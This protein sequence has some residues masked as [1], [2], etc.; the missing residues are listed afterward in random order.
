MTIAVLVLVAAATAVAVWRMRTATSAARASAALSRSQLEALLRVLPDTVTFLDAEGRT[1]LASGRSP[2]A[3]DTASPLGART[4]RHQDGTPLPAGQHPIERAMRGESFAGWSLSCR[5]AA[6]GH[7]C[8]LT[9]GGAPVLDARGRQVESV[10]VARDVSAWVRVE[11]MLRHSQK[12][13]AVGTMAAGI[14][15]DFN[16]ILTVIIGNGS[17]ARRNAADASVKPELEA[18]LHAARRGAAMTARLLAFTRRRRADVR[19]VHPGTILRALEP[20]MRRLQTPAL[21]LEVTDWTD[22]DDVVIADAAS[23]EQVIIGLFTLAQ[24]SIG[25]GGVLSIMCESAWADADAV[26]AGQRRVTI[27][28]GDLHEWFEAEQACVDAAWQSIEGA[29]P[30]GLALVRELMARYGGAVRIERTEVAGTVV[31]VSW[32]IANPSEGAA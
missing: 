26:P 1:V 11:A 6:T 27:S 22:G 9:Y 23:I 18:I 17:L 25:E 21:T 30:L 10:I 29:S 7:E 13:Q 28:V 14:T 8:L 31:T 5:D 2:Q 24:Q 32:P 3:A 20:L 19:A 16:N 12:M 15:H 4:L